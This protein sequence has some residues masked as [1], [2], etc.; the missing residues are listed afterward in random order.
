MGMQQILLILLSVIIV[1]VAVAVGM[2]MF[3]TQKASSEQQAVMADLQSFG[4]QV[5]SYLNSPAS[6]GGGSG[7]ITDATDGAGIIKWIGWSATPNVNENASYALVTAAGTCTIT[8]TPGGSNIV[9]PQA[10][11]NLAD[12]IVSI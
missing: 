11:A 4:V 2:Q 1:G 9:I 7:T 3:A 12:C 6:L 8:A 5:I 10:A